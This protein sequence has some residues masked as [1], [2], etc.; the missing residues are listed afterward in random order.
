MALLSKWVATTSEMNKN[1]LVL[2]PLKPLLLGL[3]INTWLKQS[4]L[5]IIEIENFVFILAKYMVVKV[6]VEVITTKT[7]IKPRKF[8]CQEKLA[9]EI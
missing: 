6:K 3:T 7:K 9:H 8:S 4:E 1:E 5:K 2:R